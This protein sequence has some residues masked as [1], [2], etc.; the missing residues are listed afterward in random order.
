MRFR[1]KLN[2]DNLSAF[3]EPVRHQTQKQPYTIT[4]KDI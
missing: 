1:E 3:L 4:E 2:V